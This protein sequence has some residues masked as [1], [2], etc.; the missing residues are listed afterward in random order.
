MQQSET[1]EQTAPFNLEPYDRHA[2]AI[3]AYLGQHISNASDARDLLAEVFL[4][5]LSRPGFSQLA[6]EH[7]YAWLR[8]VAHNKMI[9]RLRRMSR[10]TLVSL[11]EALECDSGELTPE[12]QSMRRESY[13]ALH[14]AIARLA[15][16]Q[17]MLLQLR[18]GEGLRLVEIAARLHK[19]DGTLRNIL[20]RTLQRLRA[21]YNQLI[22]EKEN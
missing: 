10:L 17:Q 18:Y 22:D 7:Q 8:R 14:K 6:P 5:A 9:D 3:L 20:K 11:D 15:P 2:P 4:A 21:F 16:E 1:D 19:S 13:A 12:Q